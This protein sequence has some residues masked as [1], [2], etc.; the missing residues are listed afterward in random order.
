MSLSIIKNDMN[1]IQR[2][3]LERKQTNL[4]IADLF[5]QGDNNKYA[6]NL[7]M[8][9]TSL[10]WNMVRDYREWLDDWGEYHEEENYILRLVAA[11]FCRN[12]L[13][14]ICQWRRS[15][16]QKAE[17]RKKLPIIKQNFQE[18]DRLLFFTFTA[19]TVNLENLRER[20]GQ[21]NHG[22]SNIVKGKSKFYR[23]L[24]DVMRGYIRVLEVERSKEDPNKVHPHFHILVWVTGDYFTVDHYLDQR[25]DLEV[26]RFWGQSM[27]LNYLPSVR[28]TAVKTQ[29]GD[30]GISLITASKELHKYMTKSK[31]ILENADPE[32]LA[33]FSKQMHNVRTISWGGLFKEIYKGVDQ[34]IERDLL[35]NKNDCAEK[36]FKFGLNWASSNSGEVK[37]NFN[38]IKKYDFIPS[39]QPEG[40]FMKKMTEKHWQEFFAQI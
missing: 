4:Q 16:R 3:W 1:I 30:K 32:W 26:S 39:F 14:N 17:F 10:G 22:W 24:S 28:V 5:S 18:G 35:G 2:T 27:G 31:D 33:D 6:L 21:F 38:L 19:K 37:Y 25:N 13:C 11:N 23:K 40:Y 8:C 12:R 15:L 36:C 34:E 7:A 20:I 9:S 29:K